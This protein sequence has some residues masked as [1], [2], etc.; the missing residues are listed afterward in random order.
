MANLLRATVLSIKATHYGYYSGLP[1]RRGSRARHAA[2]TSLWA[3]VQ[4]EDAGVAEVW[5]ASVKGDGKS[6]E[7]QEKQL[8]ER[9]TDLVGSNI[10][11]SKSRRTSTF[12]YEG[13]VSDPV[14]S[15]V[16]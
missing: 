16:S 4:I 3:K 7:L 13:R 8:E 10:L 1:N 14:N 2:K 9:H 6:S 5:I 12:F 15:A 11:I